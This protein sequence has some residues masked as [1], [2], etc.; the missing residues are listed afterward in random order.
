MEWIIKLNRVVRVIQSAD[1]TDG[2]GNKRRC[3]QNAQEN[4]CLV[5]PTVP[6]E[7]PVQFVPVKEED[8][9][10]VPGASSWVSGITNSDE[11]NS[12]PLKSTLLPTAIADRYL[13]LA[14][15]LRVELKQV[16]LDDHDWWVKT[17]DLNGCGI[18]KLWC[19]DCK[20]ECGGASK[21]HTKAQID[22]LF[23]NFRRFHLVSVA[24]IKNYFASKNINFEDH[25]QSESKNR[26]PITITPKDH[27][28]LIAERV[29]IMEAVNATL[30][31][32]VK[33]FALL[34][35]LAAQD[36]R[37]YWFRVKCPYCREFLVPYLP[38][39]TLEVNLRNH[40][41][42]FKHQK[43]VQDAEQLLQEPT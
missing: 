42:G 26:R 19:A 43:A 36:T 33:K 9:P 23:N 22:N 10:I 21:D 7:D 30:L 17:F 6:V 1:D 29:Q 5:E 12:N 41:S 31:E 38:R 11:T 24:Y 3:L 13:E 32:G 2:N 37:C 35:N 8:P 20:K 15:K 25:L 27:K 14:K 16:A 39:K 34:E 28:Q 40:L 4:V 18:I